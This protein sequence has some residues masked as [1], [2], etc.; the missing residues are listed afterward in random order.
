M[1]A[2]ELQLG[3]YRITDDCKGCGLCRKKCPWSAVIGAKKEKHVIEP[4]LCQGCG[5]CWNVCPK[6]AVED[7][8]GS[9]RADKGRGRV[10][11][12]RIDGTSCAGCKNCLLNCE[13]LAIRFERRLLSGHCTVDEERCV[14][15]GSCQSFC[16]SDCIGLD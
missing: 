14:G 2:R 3:G 1:E 12:A 5:T 4:T 8:D 16:A 11:K 15:C 9:K 13:Q 10:P 6:R 7:P